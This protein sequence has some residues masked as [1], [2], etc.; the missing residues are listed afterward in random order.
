MKGRTHLKSAKEVRKEILSLAKS[1]YRLAHKAGEFVPGK[2]RIPYGGRVFDGHELQNLVDSSLEFWLTAG[3]YAA[4]F[5]KMLARFI[6]VRHASLVNSGSSANLLAFA[7]LT[8]PK[9]GKRAIRSGDEVITVAAAFPTTVAPILQHGCVPVFVDVEMGTYNL[10]PSLLPRALSKKTRAVFLAHTLGNPF[11][12][13]AIRAFCRRHGLW[14]IE[15][16]CDALGAEFKGK[17]TGSFGDLSTCSFYPPH[18]MTMGEGGAVL[19]DDPELTRLVESF[20]DWGRD[21]W[22]PP[23]KDNT[24]GKRFGRRFGELPSGYDHKYV[25]SHFGYNMKATDLQAAIG[26]AQLSKLPSFIRARRKNHAFLLR[27]SRRWQDRFI[28]PVA[29]PGSDPSWFGFMLTVREDAGFSRH[30]VVEHLEK[31][32][33]QT[34]MLFAGNLIRHP[35][36]DEM[37]RKRAGYRVVGTL[38]N[39]DAV[40]NRSFWVGVYPG[41]TPRMRGH[42]VKT[43]GSFPGVREV[44]SRKSAQRPDGTA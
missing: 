25:F 37:R 4:E 43:L 26:C 22:C 13:E 36:F 8:S 38:G 28:L 18:H 11:D 19:T 6:G 24:C 40:M 27:E 2:S 3:R 16:N 35:C 17:K 31:N 33:V 21:C 34:R 5:E 39:T 29:T 10:D 20:R 23:G 44:R 41:I 15:D 1:Y 30:D 12:V 14:L 7:A 42:I 32:G 9:L